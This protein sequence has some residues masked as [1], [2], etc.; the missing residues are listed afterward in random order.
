MSDHHIHRLSSLREWQRN[1]GQIQ[2]ESLS[3]LSLILELQRNLQQGLS[4]Y[5]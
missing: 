1:L 2:P 5:A 3:D 4:C